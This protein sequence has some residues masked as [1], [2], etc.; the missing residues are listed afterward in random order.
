[1]LLGLCALHANEIVEEDLKRNLI[2]EL[3]RATDDDVGF[4][5]DRTQTLGLGG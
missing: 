1:M 2:R 3:P 4:D 5:L